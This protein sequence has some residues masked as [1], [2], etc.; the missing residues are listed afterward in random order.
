MSGQWITEP[1]EKVH[2][3]KP[4]RSPNGRGVGAL[5]QCECGCVWT[6]VTSTDLDSYDAEVERALIR[7]LVD[8]RVVVLTR[9]SDIPYRHH[10]TWSAEHGRPD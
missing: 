7:S 2:S 10:T 1:V 5:W 6:L 8:R 9:G 4:P 3:C